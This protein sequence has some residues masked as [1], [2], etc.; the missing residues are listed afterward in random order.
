MA[1]TSSTFEKGNA[2]K[3]SVSYMHCFG[4]EIVTG[5]A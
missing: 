5:D 2:G 3:K 4:K 1:R